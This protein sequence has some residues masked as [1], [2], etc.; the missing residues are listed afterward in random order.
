[1]RKFSVFVK[2]SIVP[3]GNPHCFIPVDTDVAQSKDV[4]SGRV[5]V[6][7]ELLVL[8]PDNAAAAA[9]PQRTVRRN[10]KGIDRLCFET[11]SETVLRKSAVLI[12]C[13]ASGRADPEAA[14]AR[15]GE[16]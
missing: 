9:D 11:I 3:H 15:F 6:I 1:M 16:T 12:S 4:V 2:Q 5:D 8:P 13:E 14:V 10:A 7:D